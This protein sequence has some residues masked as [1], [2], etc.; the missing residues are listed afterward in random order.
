MHGCILAFQ[1]ELN[2]EQEEMGARKKKHF[3]SM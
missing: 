2:M 3:L 1:V